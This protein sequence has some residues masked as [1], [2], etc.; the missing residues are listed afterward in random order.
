MPSAIPSGEGTRSSEKVVT[1]FLK[2]FKRQAGTGDSRGFPSLVQHGR[3]RLL[4]RGKTGHRERPRSP[5]TAAAAPGGSTAAERHRGDTEPSPR[6]CGTG[7]AAGAGQRR[8]PHGAAPL[9]GRRRRRGPAPRTENRHGGT[10]PRGSPCARPAPPAPSRGCPRGPGAEDPAGRRRPLRPRRPPH[11]HG[12]SGHRGPAGGTAP[13]GRGG[14]RGG[15]ACEAALARSGDSSRDLR[16]R[17][18]PANK[19]AA[20]PRTQNFH[21]G[22]SQDGAAGARRGR[23]G[24]TGRYRRP[25]GRGRTGRG[26]RRRGDCGR[27]RAGRTCCARRRGKGWRAGGRRSGGCGAAGGCPALPGVPQG[28]GAGAV[29]GRRRAPLAAAAALRA[30]AR[31]RLSQGG[32]LA[33]G[34]GRCVYVGDAFWVFIKKKKR[35]TNVFASFSLFLGQRVSRRAAEEEGAPFPTS[36]RVRL[37]SPGRETCA[38]GRPR[39]RYRPRT[40]A[41]GSKVL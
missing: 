39:R 12:R 4:S 33:P 21:V 1:F 24:D 36:N 38:G 14:L 23:A 6:G 11:G 34:W 35:K 3:A 29:S 32:P 31:P 40:G 8:D 20:R 26:R 22:K 17:P 10:T 27:H 19:S 9:R 2:S 28:R 13:G 18:P 16:P 25:A 5:G 15:A 7:A 37:P 30:A 41:S